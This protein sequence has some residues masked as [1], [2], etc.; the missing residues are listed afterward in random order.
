MKNYNVGILTSIIKRSL[1]KKSKIIFDNKYNII[2]DF[3]FFLRLSKKYKFQYISDPIATYRIHEKNLSFVNKDM[4]IKEF[5]HWI[6]KNK[7]KLKTDDYNNIKN[8]VYNLEFIYFKFS[9]NFF[10][11]LVFL[12]RYNKYILSFKNIIILFLPNYFLKKVMWFI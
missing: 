6:K 2:G 3:D 4:Q 7:K 12:F 1:L 9:R 10:E 5:K 8:R 11:T